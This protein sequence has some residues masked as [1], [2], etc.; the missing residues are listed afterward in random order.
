[1]TE[2]WP[3]FYFKIHKLVSSYFDCII[4]VSIV[5]VLFSS[6][7]RPYKMNSLFLSTGC[8]AQILTF[9]IRPSGDGAVLCDWVWRAGVHTGFRTIT[10][11]LYIG[12]LPNLATRFP[13]GRGRTLFILRSLG[14]RSRSSLL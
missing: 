5:V 1:M 13:C 2:F 12:S 8:I 9:F 3:C 11:V 4:F 7:I 6:L 10:L 14:Q